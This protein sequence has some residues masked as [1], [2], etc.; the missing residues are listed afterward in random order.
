MLKPVVFEVETEDGVV[1]RGNRY[2]LEGARAVVTGHGLAPPTT[3]STCPWRGST[4]PRSSTPWATRCGRPTGA[5]PATP[6][7]AAGRGT[8]TTRGTTRHPWTCPRYSPAVEA[9][10]GRRPFY[11]GHSFGGMT[12]YVYLQGTYI[13]RRDSFRV[14]RDPGPGARAQRPPGRGGDRG[15]PRLHARLRGRRHRESTALPADA[16]VFQGHGELADAPRLLCPAHPP[17]R[18]GPGLGPEAPPGGR[19]HHDRPL[20][21]L[22]PA[23]AQ[24]GPGGLRGLRHLGGRQ[25]LVQ[26]PGAH[27]ADGAPGRLR[28]LHAGRRAARP[29]PTPTVS[30]PSPR[31]W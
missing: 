13:D 31:P 11:M 24:H 28:P 19:G 5:A 15:Q 17:E 22:L 25:R 23:A 3:S 26:A 7:P 18:A 6:R 10:T 30:P 14:K 1:I 4:W 27:D 21:P 16:G 9:E 29:S 12:L 8:G 2:P 20:R